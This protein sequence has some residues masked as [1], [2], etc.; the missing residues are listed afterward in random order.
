MFIPKETDFNLS[1]HTGLTRKSWKEAGKY[2]LSALFKELKD[3]NSPMVLKRAEYSVTYPHMGA[4]AGIIEA[5][6][7]AEIFEGLARSFFIASVM[8]AEEPELKLSGISVRD[9]Y[10]LHILR[11]CTET[12]S[13]EYAGTYEEMQEL[14]GKEDPFK[15]F[16]Q[17][18]ET[19]ALVVGL[20]ASR[21][22]LWDKLSKEERDKL[23]AFLSGYAHNNT[24]P[25][26]WRLFNMLDLAF[27][28]L[29][30]YEIDRDIMLDHAGAILS[31]YAGDG[32]YRDG[33]SFDY[34][35]CWAFNTYAPLW[36]FWYGYENMPE[37]AERFEEYSNK[38]MESYP[39]FF[40]RDGYT[41]M[42]G[43]S[44]IY[45][46]AAISPFEGNLLLK[47][48]MKPGEMG[49]IRRIASG[50]LLQFLEREDFLA[51]GVPSLGFYGQF[52]PLVQSYSC[53]ASP[54]WLGKAFLFLH[55]KED[56]PFWSEKESNGFWEE[57][58]PGEVKETVL[59]G[60]GLVVTDHE[61]NGE[62]ILRS[63]KVIKA[64][65]DEE[66]LWN[67]L[68]LCY[69]TKYPWESTPVAFLKDKPEVSAESQQYVLRSLLDGHLEK[70]NVS[71]Y[72][73]HKD[74][75]L[76]RRQLFGYDM[77]TE[78]HWLNSVDLA[79][80]PVPFGIL[81]ADR[82]HIVKRP[83]EITLG[84]YGFPD[85]GSPDEE[86]GGFVSGT[87][88]I[89]L[90]RDNAGAVVLK[91]KDSLGRD[92]QL[93]MTVYSGWKEL[94]TCYSRGTDPDTR[95]SVLLYAK[96]AMLRQYDA[97]EPYIYISQ[98]ITR[99]DGRDFSE[100]EI[101]PVRQIDTDTC[102]KIRILLKNGEEKVVDFTGIEG[103]LGI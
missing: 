8:I 33:Q 68:K 29:N 14:S 31:Y 89:R 25:Q 7:R 55:L 6:R 26:N 37:I 50:S 19:C 64:P 84:A 100:D 54:L 43:R 40:D 80:F 49:F 98:V 88:I 82:I 5:E 46:F 39:S 34:Y 70:A 73:G 101:F 21:Q 41:N 61:A 4:E 13:P 59:E 36:N 90:E 79:D 77:K 76:Y 32:W 102:S 97:S 71:F 42:W 28:N 27:L 17:T 52:V 93:A 45:R 22:V 24:V 96:G 20:W 99:D 23:A 65:E 1:P 62:T 67:Y 56:H 48:G 91:G 72:A 83:M 30:G 10:R 95:Y 57:L 86:N 44:S 58:R 12:G 81:R 92:K 16:Q 75:I 66:G 38:L 18:V 87:E 51:N 69:N 94:E 3:I 103:R 35:S 53:A 74:G 15:P 63:S 60:P 85:T 78:W 9:Y 47:N 2:L 11:S